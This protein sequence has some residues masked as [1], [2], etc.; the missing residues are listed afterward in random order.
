MRRD[1]RLIFRTAPFLFALLFVTLAFGAGAAAET[2]SNHAKTQVLLYLVGSDLET[3]HATGTADLNEL[4]SAYGDTS[5]QDLDVIVAFGGADK[6]GWKGMKIAT[7][8]QLRAD[9]NTGTFGSGNDYLYS[10]TSADMGSGTSLAKFIGETEKVRTADRSILIISDH[11]NSYDGI[12]TDDI[13]KNSLKMSDISGALKGSGIS[14][15]PVMFDACLMSSVEVG[16]T[17]QPY[18]PVMLASEE[19]QRGSYN[20]ES[21]ITP[22]SEN[23]DLDATTLMKTITNTYVDDA[24]PP[25]AKTMAVIDVT[26]MQQVRSSLDTLGAKLKVIAGDDEGLH[27]LKAAYN[28]AVRLG[29]SDGSTPTS[30]DLVSLLENI[31]KKRPELA[32]DVDATIATVKSAV[33][34]ERHNGYSPTVYG[35]SI[36]SPDAMTPEKYSSLGDA[37]KIAPNW[38][39]F[40]LIM[41]EASQK[42]SADTSG[43]AGTPVSSGAAAAGSVG[44]AA[45]G[46]SL[47]SA[48]ED[49]E[50]RD[51]YDRSDK[52]D[53]K[54]PVL[55]SPGFASRGNGTYAL[56]DSYG[57]AS[58]YVTYYRIN[59]SAA[60]TIGS[61]P[62]SS[63]TDGLYRIPAW[64]GQWFYLSDRSSGTG[65]LWD[66]IVSF[67][68]GNG[69]KARPILIDM[70]YEDVT[71]GGFDEYI[72]WI[73]ME[74][75][76][77]TTE[78]TLISY[79]NSSANRYEI[80]ITPYSMTKDGN[81][82]FGGDQDIFE[83]GTLVTSYTY[84]FDTRTG[85]P[86]EY[87]LSSGSAGPNTAMMYGILPDGTYAVGLT[88]YYDNDNEQEADQFRILT[89]QNGVVVSSGI[90]PLPASA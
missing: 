27:D 11:G 24:D 80:L 7:I 14:S 22:L 34:Y 16:K 56:I 36:A 33:L 21:V 51:A 41:L 83:A 15:P 67:F 72:S 62:V 59:G 84:G 26:K 2:T 73:S 8:E 54:A 28:D 42:P 64:D 75:G 52:V 71:S 81:T 63:G 60:M 20:Y 1:T 35:I 38:D 48:Q 44:V 13:T 86:E 30:V 49:E 31:K 57:D 32:G 6:T 19:I 39:E 23:S 78:A 18:T 66:R 65:N 69:N 5:A 76:N 70:E 79:V 3:E 25:K 4:V 61:Q 58:V 12:G 29:I 77:D 68:M 10:D 40:F 17:I 50:E 89:I 53:K 37:V 43:T 74:N 55:T 90:G 85:D 82:L 87:T 45:R 47:V 46:S 88:A 9:A